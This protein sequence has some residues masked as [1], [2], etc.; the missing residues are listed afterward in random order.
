M[1]NNRFA[2]INPR[3]IFKVVTRENK[4][5]LWEIVICIKSRK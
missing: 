5:I 3:E 1:Q 4:S 2:K